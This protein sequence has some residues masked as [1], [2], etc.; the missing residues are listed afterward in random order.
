ME[1]TPI[2]T[3]LQQT[4][5]QISVTA[6][7][8]FNTLQTIGSNFSRFLGINNE[9]TD[10]EL[11]RKIHEEEKQEASRKRREEEALS[12]QLIRQLMENGEISG[13]SLGPRADRDSQSV[14]TPSEQLG[15]NTGVRSSSRVRMDS[16]AEVTAAGLLR[17]LDT[18]QGGNEENRIRIRE[19]LVALQYMQEER[20]TGQGNYETFLSTMQDVKPPANSKEDMP[21]YIW[22]AKE[23]KSAP[24]ETMCSICLSLYEGGNEIKLLPCFHQF[25]K[26]CI[27]PWLDM[28]NTCPVCKYKMD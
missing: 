19:L 7:S 9:P 2:N 6:S 24:G 16:H 22:K 10:E 21:V 13:P 25:H 8:V 1:S 20:R 12:Q 5:T 3:N 27:D 26:D 28:H 18:Y 15:S 4:L 17:F 14:T 23:E 11:A